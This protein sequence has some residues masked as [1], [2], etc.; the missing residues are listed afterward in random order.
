MP[1][2]LAITET[3]HGNAKNILA[4]AGEIQSSHGEMERIANGMTPY[5]N[6]ALPE[7]LT[8]RLLDMKKK[9]TALYEKIEQYS[10]K[11]DYA[12]DNYDW[13]DREI[14][15]WAARLGVGV[16]A[17]KGGA[18]VD[19]ITGNVDSPLGQRI[20]DVDSYSD[21][22][23]GE[24]VWYVRGRAQEKLN[25]DTGIRGNGGTWWDQAVGKGL[26]T[27][28]EIK[29][30]SIAC[31]SGPTSYGHVA[32]IERVDGDTVYYTE[33]NMEPPYSDGVISPQDGVL[34]SVSTNEFKAMCKGS[35]QGMI[36]LS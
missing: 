30:D 23:K 22:I 33:A 12:A 16:A 21:G 4:K 9:H 32:Y 7:L 20:A 27:G 34:K 1:K 10:Q 18:A 24:C 15:G 14:A 29:G 8:R 5:F 19:G 17:L 11:V 35:L 31:F 3:M 6:G 36:Y 28:Q 25:V 26:S 13:S 2:I